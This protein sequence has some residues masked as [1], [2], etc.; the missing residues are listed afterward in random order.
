MATCLTWS[1]SR[2]RRG[3]G[4][5][6]TLLSI[7]F[8]RDLVFGFLVE[9]GP[10]EIPRSAT[11]AGL[12]G[13]SA[14]GVAKLVSLAWKASSTRWASAAVSLFFSASDRCAHSAA[15]SPIRKFIEFTDK[16]ITQCSR[17]FGPERS[18]SG[19]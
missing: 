2:T 8:G 11:F 15:S 7:T 3:S 13:L 14:S 5:A 16:S 10:C 18:I 4:K 1:R 17:R 12:W 9:S 19:I 6:S